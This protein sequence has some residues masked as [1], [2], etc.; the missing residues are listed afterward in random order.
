MRL[1]FLNQNNMNK[2]LLA[3]LEPKVLWHHF[4]D[5]CEIP[6][7]VGKEGKLAEFILD[8]AVKKDFFSFIDEC[9]NLFIRIPASEGFESWPSVCLQAN[10]DLCL[11]AY[12]N[13]KYFATDL[14]KEYFPLKLRIIGDTIT[15]QGTNFSAANGIGMAAMMAIITEDIPHG[16]LEMLFSSQMNNLSEGIMRFDCSCIESKYLINLCGMEKESAVIIGSPEYCMLRIRSKI[17]TINRKIN[18]IIEECQ[19]FETI[20]SWHS[21]SNCKL[22]FLIQEAYHATGIPAN[23]EHA[24]ESSDMSIIN[25]L[26]PEIKK[27]SIGPNGSLNGPKGEWVS[28]KSVQKFWM[29]LKYILVNADKL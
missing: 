25:K 26:M 24:A 18:P 11:L 1:V 4:A 9:S 22:L 19:Q 6:H 3:P 10:I 13:N 20:S 7:E 12:K 23:I 17:G 27:I 21:D 16:P 8:L 29:A 5:I 2:K 15:S 28:I 14:E